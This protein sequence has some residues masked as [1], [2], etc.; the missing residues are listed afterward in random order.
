MAIIYCLARQ[1]SK[2]CATPVKWLEYNLTVIL[3]LFINRNSSAF[4]IFAK[5]SRIES[6]FF[7]EF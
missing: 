2:C 3:F 5:T 1:G 7:R 6:F 4:N